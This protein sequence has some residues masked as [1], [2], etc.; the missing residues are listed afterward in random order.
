MNDWRLCYQLIAM[1]RMCVGQFQKVRPTSEANLG[2]SYDYASIMHYST[3]SGS[4]NGQPTMVP[5]RPVP[6]GVVIG[7]RSTLSDIDIAE[8]Q[9]MYNCNGQTP[10][11]NPSALPPSIR[12]RWNALPNREIH[13]IDF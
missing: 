2:S 11:G 8:I 9:R 3:T 12:C 1:F 7:Q 13:D 4:K 5:L 6:A 10:P